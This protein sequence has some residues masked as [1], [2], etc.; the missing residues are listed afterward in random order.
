MDYSKNDFID[1]N[2]QLFSRAR[3]NLSQGEAPIK[4]SE[5]LQDEI[6]KLQV[7]G[8]E[9][10]NNLKQ[11]NYTY[12]QIEAHIFKPSKITKKKLGQLKT[13]TK[14]ET[15]TEEPV[16]AREFKLSEPAEEPE[17]ELQRDYSTF[18]LDEL[19][20][21]L[22]FIKTL[23]DDLKKRM[24]AATKKKEVAALQ[25]DIN[26]Q[27]EISEL[28]IEEIKKK[29]SLTG[30]GRKP[31]AKSS[32]PDIEDE[33]DVAGLG[34]NIEEAEELDDKLVKAVSSGQ[35]TTTPAAISKI[36]ELVLSLIQFIGRTT[37]LYI[38]RIKKNLSYLDEDKHV[39][40]LFNE[41]HKLNKN[42][43]TLNKN[44]DKAG[45]LV[46]TTLFSQ[47]EKETK[48]LILEIDNSIRN[49]SKLKNYK[50]LQGDYV[51]GYFIQSDSPFI[52]HST[53]KRFL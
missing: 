45:V 14:A 24:D 50:T 22:E 20:V 39:Q 23:I 21:E 16:G 53:T 49:Y 9:F 34:E 18:T 42:L 2:A 52:K 44:K 35:K 8:S 26:K 46:K 43:D 33:D 28:I 3:R 1:I 6:D 17:F 7:Y 13:P 29:S 40:V 11:I 27:M 10:I 48:E 15:K 12:E 51:G 37:V 32:L 30:K 5:D 38:S 47:L 41:M 19:K 25:K 4:E 36:N 31:K